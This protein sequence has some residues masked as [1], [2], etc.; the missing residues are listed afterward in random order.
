[1]NQAAAQTRRVAEGILGPRPSGTQVYVKRANDTRVAPVEFRDAVEM[2]ARRFGAHGDVVWVPDQVVR[3]E[4]AE[5][6]ASVACWQVRFTL[7]HGDPRL[8]GREDTLFETVELHYWVDPRDRKWAVEPKVLD[9]LRRDHRNRRRP[10]YVAYDLDELG[11]EGL[12]TLLE[13]GSTLSGRGE[14]RS[15]V[16]A[17]TVMRERHRDQME[18]T[19]RQMQDTAGYK[20]EDVRRQVFKIPYLGV[21]IELRTP[22]ETA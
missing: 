13:K 14:F 9:R 22:K 18:R 15:A 16:H 3:F 10:G 2:F 19:R 6:R 11:V 5:I 1:M 17:A 21:G 4:G 7:L 12:I 8:K 20:A